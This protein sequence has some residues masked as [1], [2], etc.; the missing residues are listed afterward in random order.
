MGLNMGPWVEVTVAKDG[1]ES[2]EADLRGT[3]EH[4]QVYFPVTDSTTISIKSSRVT[5]EDAVTPYDLKP[6]ATGDHELVTTARATA[7]VV[8]FPNVYAQYVTIVLSAAQS[9]AART[10]YIR[11]IHPI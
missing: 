11:G 1:T 3:F 8:V 2:S 6:A 7:G 4:V 5:G 10:F 9:T